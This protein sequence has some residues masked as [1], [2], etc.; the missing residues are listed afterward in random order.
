MGACGP[1]SRPEAIV[2]AMPADQGKSRSDYRELAPGYD[3]RTRLT[4]AI[5]LEAVAALELRPGD[6]VLDV[7][8]GTGFCFP[9][10]LDRIG[11]Q[12]L[13]LGFDSS[14]DLLSQARSRAAANVRIFESAAEN[15]RLEKQ[16]NAVLFSY[17]HDV[18]QSEAALENL[19]GQAAPGA[20]VAACGSVLW[21]SWAWPVNAW[22]RARHRGYM[23]NME[24]FDRPWVKLA[25]RLDG[26][27]VARRGPG[28][29]YLAAGVLRSFHRSAA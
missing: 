12:G 21:P 1:D 5:R 18:L 9:A 27:R 20:R 13:L 14:P 25:L 28:W 24:N 6:T 19:L 7:A 15:A 11:P 26:F 29:R 4:D 3:G 22:L 16:P 8:C 2:C 17:A 10:I 23:T